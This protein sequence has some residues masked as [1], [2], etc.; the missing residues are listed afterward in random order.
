MLEVLDLCDTTRSTARRNVTN[1]PTQAL[2]LLNGGFV[3]R[4]AELFAD[5]LEREAGPE[6]AAQV[7]QAYLLTVCRWPSQVERTTLLGFLE[8][9]SRNRLAETARAEGALA[10]DRARHEAL[11]QLCRA[12]FNMNEFVYPD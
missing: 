7:E 1:V 3:N 2:T 9:E 8:R 11:V 5:R 12:L 4:Q 6:P 10:G